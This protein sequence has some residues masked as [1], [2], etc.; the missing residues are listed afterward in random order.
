MKLVETI[1]TAKQGIAYKGFVPAPIPITLP[2]RC[3]V[4]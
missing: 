3:L 1:I 4:Q 2:P